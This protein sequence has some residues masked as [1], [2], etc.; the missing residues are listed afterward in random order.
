MSGGKSR[1]LF[2]IIEIFFFV[3][4]WMF[5]QIWDTI[6]RPAPPQSSVLLRGA[7]PTRPPPDPD[8]TLA[9]TIARLL[10]DFTCH[11]RAMTSPAFADS[12]F[13]IRLHFRPQDH[14][15]IKNPSMTSLALADS[16]L[17][18]R[19][20]LRPEDHMTIEKSSMTSP[21]FADSTFNIRLHL[22]PE[23]HMI[24]ENPSVTWPAFADSTFHI[25]LHF[26]PEGHMI[27]ENPSMTSPVFANSTLQISFPADQKTIWLWKILPWLHLHP[28]ILPSAYDVTID[29]RT[30]WW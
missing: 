7:L 11:D 13:Y 29:Q 15:I 2:F 10:H 16:T 12:T 21:A 22:R 8:P 3:R 19:L 30:I 28:L 18:I 9:R 4:F 1:K 20:H 25:R 17:H 23:D 27:I 5:L 24:V 14:M 6:G 26:R